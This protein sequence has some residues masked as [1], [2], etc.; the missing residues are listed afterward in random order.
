MGMRF[1]PPWIT[2]Q[3]FFRYNLASL[4]PQVLGIFAAGFAVYALG[5]LRGVR[6]APRDLLLL[7]AS[8]FA[9]GLS[10]PIAIGILWPAGPRVFP[11][12]F[13]AGLGLLPQTQ[14]AARIGLAP[15]ALVLAA[16]VPFLVSKSVEIN[17]DYD[18]FLAAAPQ[19]E[20]GKKLLPIVVDPYAGARQVYP[21]WSIASMYSTLRGGGN[22][23]VFASPYWKTGGAILA[24]RRYAEDFPYCY[25]YEEQPLPRYEAD[26]DGISRSYDYV[27][28]WGEAAR[29]RTLLAERMDVV[30]DDGALALFRA[31]TAGA[32]EP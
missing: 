12:A 15:T 27:L 11:F 4:A 19:L 14:R 28:V 1:N 32:P 2:V 17:R 25:Q 9:I 10:M 13:L 30:S 20:S 16:A 6:T 21:F 7:T 31:R 8:L 24:Y 29:L 3:A 18:A 26:V 22:P 23:Y 5:I